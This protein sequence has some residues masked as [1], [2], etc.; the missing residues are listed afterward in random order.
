MGP[1]IRDG[2]RYKVRFPKRDRGNEYQEL[3]NS[4]VTL[5]TR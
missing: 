1:F 3:K 2:M 4:T 5:C